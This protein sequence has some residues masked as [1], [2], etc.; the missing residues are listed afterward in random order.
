MAVIDIRREHALGIDDART[1]AR[2]VAVDLEQGYGMTCSWDGDLLRFSRP[3]V[4]GEL[5]VL[6]DRIEMQARLGILLAGFRGRIEAQLL[7]NFDTYFG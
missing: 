4:E 1:A 7:K 3:G 2:R 5:S 6:P